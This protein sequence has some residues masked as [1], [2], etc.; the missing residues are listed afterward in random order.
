MSRPGLKETDAVKN[1]RVYLVSDDTTCA[2]RGAAGLYYLAGWFHPDIFKD[3]DP[4]A[5]HREMLKKFYGEELRG[6]WVYPE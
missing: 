5:V 4:E 6:I 3:V 1:G 2:P